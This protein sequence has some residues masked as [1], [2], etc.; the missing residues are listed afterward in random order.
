MNEQA[1]QGFAGWPSLGNKYY[2]LNASP[3]AARYIF[4]PKIYFVASHGEFSH[5]LRLKSSI[6]PSWPHSKKHYLIRRNGPLDAAE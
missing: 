1:V 5:R 2:E 4:V 3:Q 6:A